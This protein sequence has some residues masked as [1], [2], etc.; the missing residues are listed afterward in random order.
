MKY[1]VIYNPK[2]RVGSHPKT[3]KSIQYKLRPM[4]VE[5]HNIL[6]IGNPEAFLNRLTKDDVTIVVGGDGTL[7][8]LINQVYPLDDNCNLAMYQ[9]GTGND[10]MRSLDQKK[11]FPHINPYLKNLPKII[12]NG[13]THYFING[14]GIGLDG[15]VG[16]MIESRGKKKSKFEFF[17]ST[18]VAIKRFK[19][20]TSHIEE[21]NSKTTFRHT[22]FISVMFGP[23]FGGGM[24]IA[25]KQSRSLDTLTMVI[26]KDCPKWLLFIIF[27]SIYFGKHTMFKKYVTLKEIKHVNIQS[28]INQT[29]Q[30][31]GEVVNM[32]QSIE[33]KR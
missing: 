18:L 29:V 4:P 5:F 31:D 9:S 7:H 24:N 11:E 27:P 6:E 21:N 2:S 17:K 12:I 3:L 13:H 30:M 14:V 8:H 23:F 32:I 25:P 1:H 15:Y 26:V 28:E 22:W 10:F 16:H 20:F 19:P 33:I